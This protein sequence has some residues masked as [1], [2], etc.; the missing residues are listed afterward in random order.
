MADQDLTTGGAFRTTSARGSIMSVAVVKW[1]IAT[2][3]GRVHVSYEEGGDDDETIISCAK[4]NVRRQNGGS[5]PY[6]GGPCCEWWEIVERK[7][8]VEAT[9]RLSG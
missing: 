3:S 5:L 7:S 9:A 1:Q 8:D 4:S 2:Y 6:P